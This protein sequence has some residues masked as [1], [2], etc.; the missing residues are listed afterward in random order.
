MG[1]ACLPNPSRSGER[2]GTGRTKVVYGRSMKGCIVTRGGG[3]A[4]LVA[5]GVL[6]VGM[7]TVASG[8]GAPYFPY[9]ACKP[10]QTTNTIVGDGGNNVLNGTPQSDLILALGG[11]D[12]ADGQADR[13]CLLM[14]TG[15]D[16]ATGS[17]QGDRVFGEPGSDRVAGGEGNDRVD[18]DS[19]RDRV[20]GNSGRDFLN[21]DSGDDS[22]SGGPGNDR[23]NGGSDDDRVFGGSDNDLLGAGSGDDRVD[24]DSGRDGVS[25]GPGDDRVIGGTGRRDRMFGR[26]GNDRLNAVDNVR[27]AIVNCGPGR[28]RARIDFV[29]PVSGNCEIVVQVP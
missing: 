6:A 4:V 21:G 18:G 5:T 23:G 26:T 29:D 27:D 17:G 1:L 2:A 7:S 22:V 8:Q 13:D 28:D 16:R 24:G 11:N 25:G 3:L 14:G 15:D 20:K 19:G 12:R 9:G 10:I